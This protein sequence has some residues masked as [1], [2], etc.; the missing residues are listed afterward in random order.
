MTLPDRLLP[1]VCDL[2]YEKKMLVMLTQSNGE[3]AVFNKKFIR[4]YLQFMFP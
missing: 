3:C 4:L 1:S 2:L